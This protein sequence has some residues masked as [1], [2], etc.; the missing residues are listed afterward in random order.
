MPDGT[1]PLPE[2][3]VTSNYQGPV[4]ITSGNF[5]KETSAT[6]HWNYREITYLKIHSNPP[7]TN[8]LIEASTVYCFVP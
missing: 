3:M 7:G 5:T 2:P 8:E 6:N 1:K 4:P